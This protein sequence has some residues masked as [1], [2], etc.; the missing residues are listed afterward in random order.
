MLPVMVAEIGKISCSS[1][2]LLSAPRRLHCLSEA[3]SRGMGSPVSQ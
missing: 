3:L 1:T 2:V